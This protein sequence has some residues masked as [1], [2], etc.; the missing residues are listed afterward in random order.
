MNEHRFSKTIVGAADLVDA[1]SSENK[2][3]IAFVANQLSLK[4]SPVK[5]S[6]E[7]SEPVGFAAVDALEIERYSGTASAASYPTK[8][9][10]YCQWFLYRLSWTSKQKRPRAS[11]K[12]QQTYYRWTNC[13][14]EAPQSQPVNNWNELEPR[15]HNTLV[16]MDSTSLIDL[17][18]VIETISNGFPVETIPRKKENRWSSLQVIVDT[19]THLRSFLPDQ[20]QVVQNIQKN[21]PADQIEVYDGQIPVDLVDRS[22]SQRQYQPRSP[23]TMIMVLGDLGALDSRPNRKK[24]WLD[25]CR[26]L[27]KQGFTVFVLF[28]SYDSNLIGNIR[29][30]AVPI[31]WFNSRGWVSNQNQREKLVQDLFVLVSP[32]IIVPFGLIR[33]LR[34]LLPKGRMDPSLEIDFLKDDRQFPFNFGETTIDRL[35]A[36]RNLLPRF[37]QLDDWIKRQALLVIRKWMALYS[38]ERWFETLLSLSPETQKLLANNDPVLEKDFEDASSFFRVVWQRIDKKDSYQDGDG[39]STYCHCLAN[40][41]NSHL[42]DDKVAGEVIKRIREELEDSDNHHPIDQIM[43]D[44]QLQ[45]QKGRLF[46][47]G[48]GRSLLTAGSINTTGGIFKVYDDAAWDERTFWKAGKKPSFVTDFGKDKYGLWFEV[49]LDFNKE[50]PPTTLRFRWIPPGKFLMGSP[51]SEEGRT[52][53]EKQHLVKL[54]KGFWM[55]DTPITQLA[56]QHVVGERPSR[57]SGPNRP[58]ER[59]SW[60]DAGQALNAVNKRI[61]GAE[62]RLPTEAQWE[63]ACRAGTTTVYSFGDE[64]TSANANFSSKETTDVKSYP[65]NDWGLFDMHGNV[66]EWCN[67]WCRDYPNSSQVAVDPKGLPSGSDR[68]IRGGSWL[69]DVR[70]IR[71]AYR[72]WTD[73]ENRFNSLGFRCVSSAKAAEPAE[74]LAMPEAE[75]GMLPR[76]AGGARNPFRRIREIRFGDSRFKNSFQIQGDRLQITGESNSLEFIK[77]EKPEWATSFGR[78]RYGVFSE[79][80]VKVSNK[81]QTEMEAMWK[82]VANPNFRPIPDFGTITQRMR[83]I[84]PGRFTMGSPENEPGRYYNEKQQKVEIST[85][86]WMFDTPCTQ[87]LWMAVMGKNPSHF[88]DPERPVESV[89]WD[90]ALAFTKKLGDQVPNMML[91][92][93]AQWESACRAGTKGPIYSGELEIISDFNAPNLDP[94][95]WYSGNSGYEFDHPNPYDISDRTEKQYEFDGGGTRK[96]QQKKPNPFG[97]FDMLG[98]VWEWCNDWFSDDFDASEVAVDP[99]GPSEGSD[100]VI[101]GGSWFNDAKYVRSASRDWSAPGNRD[102]HLGFR[103]VSSASQDPSE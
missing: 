34:L 19:N 70:G 36:R 51:E 98:N 88:L 68:V 73:P 28:P 90:D 94:I 102:S 92:T 74:G 21:F 84:A 47:E 5:N 33:D 81:T 65:C 29:H 76:K 69:G 50:L 46:A 93:E 101:R 61:S 54:S 72:D 48:E 103:C 100:R 3:L 53:R 22:N 66:Y 41:S 38:S 86:Y 96:V 45:N 71:S 40:R 26:S 97:L 1:I 32:A 42:Q 35:E 20:E 80:Q 11:G 58:V 37:E 83:W 7:I 55:S 10:S 2:E 56:W 89:N 78:D 79:F 49:I 4:F 30:F 63:Y 60:D 12:N 14:K 6:S 52:S 85:G 25:W 31:P 82:K 24:H 75:P 39:F 57:F 43:V 91:P 23:E 15:I 17:D 99:K 27:K 8:V 77:L 13:P 87:A 64:A 67:D 62:T 95:A 16:R 18:K 9:E 59:V 44:L